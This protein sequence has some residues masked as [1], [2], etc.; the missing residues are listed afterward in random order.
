MPTMT[1]SCLK[2]IKGQEKEP[3][4]SSDIGVSPQTRVVLSCLVGQAE[5]RPLISS[6]PTSLFTED[7]T[8]VPNSLAQSYHLWEA[9][10]DQ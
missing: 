9:P 10:V 3:P 5:K 4:D 8:E 7:H 1:S 6:T 2:G